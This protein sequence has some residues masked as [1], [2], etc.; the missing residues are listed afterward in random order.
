MC[1]MH[2][3]RFLTFF[4]FGMLF[5]YSAKS[6]VWCPLGDGVNNTVR[7]LAEYNSYLYVGGSFDK[8]GNKYISCIAMYNEPFWYPLTKSSRSSAPNSIFESGSV[9]AL[10]VFKNKLYIGGNFRRNQPS[11]KEYI[12]RWDEKIITSV[13]NGV[14]K[15][16]SNNSVYALEVY[17]DELYAGGIFSSTGSMAANNIA[18]WDDTLWHSLSEGTNGPVYSLVNYKDNVN[19][20]NS[21]HVGGSFT[22]AGN[23]NANNTARWNTIEPIKLLVIEPSNQTDIAQYL[24]DLAPPNLMDTIVTTAEFSA[25]S[26]LYDYNVMIVGSGITDYSAL[27]SRR[28][29]IQDYINAGNGLIVLSPDVN[30]GLS[31]LPLSVN[32]EQYTGNQVTMS[33]PN[34]PILKELSNTLLS[35]W[36]SSYN[37]YFSSFDALNFE[38]VA[39][40]PEIGNY[41]I[42]L[43]GNFGLGRIVITGQDIDAHLTENGASR[44]FSNILQWVGKKDLQIISRWLNTGN[45]LNGTVYCFAIYNG[46][47]YAGGNF[48]IAGTSVVN[49]AKLNNDTWEGIGTLGLSGPVLSLAVHQ[50]ELYVGGKFSTVDGITA[51]N[52]AKWNSTNW[53]SVG[54]G[55]DDTVY[56]LISYRNLLYAGG[57]FKTSGGITVNHIA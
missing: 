47:L 35:N 19:Y 29:E 15:L 52:I 20:T 24:N 46:E 16:N 28:L 23:S 42:T 39:I 44:L 32:G 14:G 10:S 25:L 53:Q 5:P 40:T 26:N 51:N 48:T 1:R 55:F 49:I 45:G 34:H 11:S 38:S 54:E 37:N 43:T 57:A 2:F 33:K 30:N 6:Q 36:N 8:A 7:A 50:N 18:T 9:Y 12:I 27:T 13:G 3:F 41:P 56:A 4:L 21:L 17:N 31:W 22:R